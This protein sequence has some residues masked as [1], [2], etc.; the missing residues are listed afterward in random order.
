MNTKELEDIVM[1]AVNRCL[2]N[3]HGTSKTRDIQKALFDLRVSYGLH[4]LSSVPVI[5]ILTDILTTKPHVDSFFK[6]VYGSLILLTHDDL[7]TE[8]NS[9]L[10]ENILLRTSELHSVLNKVIYR[11]GEYLTQNQRLSNSFAHPCANIRKRTSGNIALLA[12]LMVGY[13]WQGRA[14]F[15]EEMLVKLEELRND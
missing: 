6:D 8:I 15:M 3:G 4:K 13:F 12:M 14:L 10:I 1:V 2:V 7:T 11:D 9:D 5:N